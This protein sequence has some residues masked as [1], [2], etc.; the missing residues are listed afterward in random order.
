M[1]HQHCAPFALPLRNSPST[2]YAGGWL[3]PRTCV[4]RYKKQIALLPT[5]AWNQNCPVCSESLY[6]L[7]RRFPFC[8]KTCRLSNARCGILLLFSIFR[9]LIFLPRFSFRVISSNCLM[10][11]KLLMCVLIQV[12]VRTCAHVSSHHFCCLY[13][14]FPPSLNALSRCSILPLS[15]LMFYMPYDLYS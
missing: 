1:V 5:V 11:F 9:H 10:D 13:F 6:R 3:G 14:P 12:Y 8:W 15:Q 4:D 2:H 7:S